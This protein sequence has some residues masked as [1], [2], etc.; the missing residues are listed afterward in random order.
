MP[1]SRWKRLFAAGTDPVES[2]ELPPGR[3]SFSMIATDAPA[4]CA[5]IAAARPQAPAPMTSTSMS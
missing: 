4:S 5:A 2:D 1:A 3:S